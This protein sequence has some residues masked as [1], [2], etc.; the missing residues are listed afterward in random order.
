MILCLMNSGAKQKITNIKVKVV[1]VSR[2][3][4][5]VAFTVA[6]LPVPPPCDISGSIFRATLSHE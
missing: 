1:H 4:P 3:E 2:K 5:L 6:C